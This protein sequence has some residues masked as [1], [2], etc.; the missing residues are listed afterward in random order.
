MCRQFSFSF[1]LSPK[2]SLVRCCIHLY[3]RGDKNYDYNN[4]SRTGYVRDEKIFSIRAISVDCTTLCSRTRC[5]EPFWK[6]SKSNICASMRQPLPNHPKNY[7]FVTTNNAIVMVAT[8]LSIACDKNIITRS[9]SYGAEHT[10]SR[11]N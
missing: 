9:S 3:C 10:T 2:C 7:E 8:P 6:V 4:N 1:S 5:T 11:V